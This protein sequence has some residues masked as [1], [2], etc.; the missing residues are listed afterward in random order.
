MALFQQVFDFDGGIKRH[1]RKFAVH[2]AGDAQRVSRAVEEIGVT[3]GDVLR[4]LLNLRANVGQHQFGWDGEE[5]TMIDR[6]DR[7]VLAGMLAAAR[8]FRIANNARLAV[9]FHPGIAVERR[10]Y[11]ALWQYHRC[12]L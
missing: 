1:I 12:A 8:G 2:R 5:T 11:S 4:A 6:S 3:K 7:A 10:E 9:P